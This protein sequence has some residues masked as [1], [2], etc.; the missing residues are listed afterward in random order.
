MHGLTIVSEHACFGG[1]Q[2]FFEHASRVIGLP[3]K[4]GVYL[5]PQVREGRVPV[6]FY[7][8]GLTCT[9]QTFSIKAGAQRFAA[10]L[11]LMLVTPDTSP[12]ATGLVDAQESW[13]LGE[14]AGFYIDA[15]HGAWAAHW[16][17]ESYIAGELREI[18][19]ES[20]AADPLRMGIFGHSMGGHGALTLALKHPSIYRSVSA[21]A[22]VAAPTR[23]PWGL[24]A[25]GAYLGDDRTT[26]ARHDA[27][28]L[29]GGGARLP[30]V[31]I[32]QG[33]D[34]K[35]LDE[36]LRLD[37]FEVACRDA[38]QPVEVRRHAGYDHSYF[39][40]STFAEEHLRH[41]A[42]YLSS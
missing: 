33:L 20:F 17:M 23:C 10:E 2:R 28:E 6:L 25:F 34:D 37:D 3:M 1:T 13:D 31:L 22:P 29:I 19:L 8:A 24:K 36:Q 42:R 21:F 12:R 5:P 32:D 15:T 7:L 35:F 4:F 38:G 11:G 27:T 16:R 9:E 39:F 41:H 14:G 26:W 30:P 40:I 18:M